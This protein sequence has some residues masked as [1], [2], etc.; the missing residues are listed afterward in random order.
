[1]T[2]EWPP[3]D[4]SKNVPPPPAG[5]AWRAAII[6]AAFICAFVLGSK[7]IRSA[8][9]ENQTLVT[10]SS[11]FENPVK[12]EVSGQVKKPG[13]YELPFNSRVYQAIA[14]AGGLLPGAETDSLNLAAWVEDGGKIEVPAKE[15]PAE[16]PLTAESN[17]PTADATLE[18]NSTP[19]TPPLKSTF[20]TA[21]PAPS[22]I[23][24]PAAPKNTPK[25]APGS[26]IDLNRAT[27]ENLQQLPGVGPAMAERILQY[28]KENQGFT[29][30]DELNNVRGIGPKKFEKMQPFVIVKPL[31]SQQQKKNS[32]N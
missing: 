24:S 25:K 7:F 31:P 32:G 4:D 13:V 12:V 16:P 21:S 20:T 23:K 5:Y 14:K 19:E 15:K 18:V 17:P 10:P 2:P 27:A 1:M 22:K 28:R 8:P 26:P 6:V 3:A 29:T 30:V 11:S 9:P